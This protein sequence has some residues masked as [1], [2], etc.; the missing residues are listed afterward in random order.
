MADAYLCPSH[1]ESFSRSVLEAMSFSLPIVTTNAYALPELVTH[2]KSALIFPVGDIQNMADA[3]VYLR[4]HPDEA[5]QFGEKARRD[6]QN[7]FSQHVVNAAY[8][9]LIWQTIS[10]EA[11]FL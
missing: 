11:R 8:D 10:K 5:R 1:S 6:A 7:F 9:R 4:E 2:Q 3:L